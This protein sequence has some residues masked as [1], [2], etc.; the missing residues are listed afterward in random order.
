MRMQPF[1]PQLANKDVQFT[2]IGDIV[3]RSRYDKMEHVETRLHELLNLPAKYDIA[4][5]TSSID[6]KFYSYSEMCGSVRVVPDCN[7]ISLRIIIDAI[8]DYKR[9]PANMRKYNGCEY[10][11]S[12]LEDKYELDV[13]KINQKAKKIVFL[14]GT[15][16]FDRVSKEKIDELFF[17]NKDIYLKPH[18]LTHP[19]LL[20]TLIGVFGEN[21]ILHPKS[22]GITYLRNADEVWVTTC[23]ELAVYAIALGKRIHDIT[24]FHTRA[25]GLVFPILETIFRY[26]DSPNVV[27][28]ALL[29]VP[30]T[31]ILYPEMP[32]LDERIMAF[33][34]K[35]MQ[36]KTLLAPLTPPIIYSPVQGQSP[37]D[38]GHKSNM[39]SIE[40]S[41]IHMSEN[42][43][44][45]VNAGYWKVSRRYK[46]KQKLGEN[47]QINV[48]SNPEESV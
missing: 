1:V 44:D 31:G 20:K 34:D 13:G 47:I 43:N 28:D 15:N 16:A 19:N 36:Y 26:A 14:P 6:Y 23:T 17:Y 29:N 22:S 4:T 11:A 32:D 10:F 48:P 30:Y 41:N 12:K 42:S 8:E 45:K 21:R 33:Q 46:I 5:V 7:E 27:L 37:A 24:N 40:K 9:I 39:Q 18:P 38:K 3:R 35:C 25:S 2:K